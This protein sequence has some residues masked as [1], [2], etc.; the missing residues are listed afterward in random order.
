MEPAPLPPQLVVRPFTTKEAR[1]LGVSPG[2]LRAADLW[3]PTSGVRSVALPSGLVARARAFAA[4]APGEFAFSHVTAAQ[5]LGLPL[6]YAIEEDCRLH[7]MSHTPANRMRRL[8]VV[9]HRGLESRRV[10]DVEGLPVVNPADTWADLGE[11]VGPGKPVGL[12]D[13]IIAGDVAARLAGSVRALTEAVA[14]RVR[15]RGKVTLTYAIPFLRPRSRSAMETRSRL[16]VVRAGLPEP[17]LNIDLVSRFGEWLGCG[18]LVWKE[19]RVVGEF[20]G[21]PFHCRPKTKIL[22]AG[23]RRSIEAGDW[24]FVEILSD[25]VFVRHDRAAKLFEL[26]DHLAFNPLLVDVWGS[27]PQFF[28]PAQFA[29]PRRPRAN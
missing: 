17:E 14:R 4:A 2:R 12:D 10:V 21:V 29:P 18:D 6:A 25:D 3:T 9:G 8:R 5:L 24:S 28:A 19:Q 27:E 16:M 15:P 13:L 23:R 22:D 11:Y 26:A 7:I 1:A 20:Q